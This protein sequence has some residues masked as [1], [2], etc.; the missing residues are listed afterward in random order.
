MKELL[1]RY[2]G[3]PRPPTKATAAL[4]SA[5]GSPLLTE[6]TQILQRWAEQFRGVFNRP[7]N[8]SDT[9]I[10]RLPQ[11][12]T[13]ADLDL[14][15]F[16]HHLGRKHA[17]E[18]K[19][20]RHR[21]RERRPYH[22]QGEGDGYAST[23]TRPCPRNN[24]EQRGRAHLQAV[25]NFTY[26]GSTLTHATKIDDEVAHRISKPNARHEGLNCAHL[27]MPTVNRPRPA[28]DASRRSGHQPVSMDIFVPTYPDDTT[29]CPPSTTAL[30]H[31]PTNSTDRTP[32]P[33]LPSCS[34]ASI[35]AATGTAH[36][37]TARNLNTSKN[38][39]LTTNNTSDVD[40]IHTCPHC[41]RAFTSHTGLISH[42]QI[43]RTETGEPVPGTPTYTRRIR[44]HYP[45]TIVRPSRPTMSAVCSQQ[46]GQDNQLV[47]LRH[48]RQEGVQV[49][50]EFVLCG[51]VGVGHRRSVGADDGGEFAPRE[52]DGGSSGDR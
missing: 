5:D 51:G 46:V 42:L 11:V 16:L 27:A 13:N 20:L 33:P 39:N 49:L 18:F 3:C 10:A 45:H 38:I 25:G 7:S 26:L 44:P 52:A 1:R 2:Q 4:F 28:H 50:V 9:A 48:S 37:A 24:P 19:P 29:R 22:Q 30:P 31:T 17:N 21:L 8:I 40:S 15:P 34:V 32:D 12:E 36:T 14:A 47:R 41:D 23:P 6:K 43:H 35:P